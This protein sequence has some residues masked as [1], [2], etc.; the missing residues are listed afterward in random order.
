MSNPLN[1][2][3]LEFLNEHIGDVCNLNLR[4]QAENADITKLSVDLTDY[5]QTVLRRVIIPNKLCCVSHAALFSLNL[6]DPVMLLP[7]SAIYIGYESHALLN[8]LNLP[9][10]TMQ[11]FLER[12]LGLLVEL[13]KQIQ[14]RLPDNVNVVNATEVLSGKNATSQVKPSTVSLASHF[15][16]V[17]S[18]IDETETMAAVIL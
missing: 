2:P 15:K 7:V 10:E 4:F 5:N 11:V 12:C 13:A 9:Q 3:Y 1:L 6:A 8:T 18:S 17:V 16:G 14:I